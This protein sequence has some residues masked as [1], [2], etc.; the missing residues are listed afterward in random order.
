MI[1]RRLLMEGAAG[2]FFPQALKGQGAGGRNKVVFQH[3]VPDLLTVS[4]SSTDSVGHTW[5]PDSQEVLDVTLRADRTLAALLHFLD[6]AVGKGK[7]LV[8]LTADHGSC[9]SGYLCQ[10]LSSSWACRPEVNTCN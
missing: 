10:Q 3:D 5:G 7:Y 8:C 9:P 2:L 1:S 6:D 4:F